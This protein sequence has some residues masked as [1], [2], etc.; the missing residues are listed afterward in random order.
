MTVEDDRGHGFLPRTRKSRA[1][2]AILALTSPKPVLRVTLA[3]ML[4]SRREKEQAR[5]SLRQSVHELQDTLGPDWSHLFQTDRHYL[6]LKGND[7][8]VDAPSAN[9]TPD[10]S[11]EAMNRYSHPLLEDLH[12]LDPAFD[13]W[14]DE[15]RLRCQRIGRTIGE[16]LLAKA[17]DPRET[18]AAA[19]G[20]LAL[21]RAHEGAWRA[22]MHG[23]AVI[24]EHTAA[25]D[26]Y[27][28]C[29]NALIGAGTARPSR[30][31]EELAE[32]LRDQAGGGQWGGQR[33]NRTYETAPRVPSAVSPVQP[34]VGGKRDNGQ[35]RLLVSPLRVIGGDRD[36]FAMAL[37]E[38]IS[39]GLSRFRWLSC[40]PGGVEG[41]EVNVMD[42]DMVLEGTVQ[43]AGNR[44]RTIV[45]L[46]DRRIDGE[47]IWAGRF[48]RIMTDPLS[49][50]DELGASIVAQI[51]PE[52]MRHE[53]KRTSQADSSQG[54]ARDLL[55]R[56][57]PGIYRLDQDSFLHARQLLRASLA[58]D[59]DSS[60]TNGWLAYWN[61]LY[62]GQG[63]AE[64]SE[65]SSIE[66][67]RL[68][69]RAVMLDPGDARAL[70]LAGHVRGF[71]DKRPEE[72]IALHERAI[73]LN[74]NMALAWCFSGLAYFYIGQHEEALRRIRQAISLSPSDPHFFFFDMALILPSMMVGD[75]PGAIAA[76]RRAIEMN[77]Q[78]SS[79]YKG[80]LA[81]LGHAGRQRDAQDVL[82]R[83]MRLEPGFSVREAV[84]R[85]PMQRTE[86]ID[87]YAE[88][89]RRAGL[90]ESAGVNDAMPPGKQPASQ[91][92][93]Q[94]PAIIIE[95]SRIDLV[96][97]AQH[98]PQRHAG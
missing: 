2:L 14:L 79:S 94:S 52:L 25:L 59:P 12:G 10:V 32:R 28:D 51:D 60:E 53:G 5:A 24:G 90:Q 33:G 4:W 68:A 61:L 38:E 21:D 44:V 95:H 98:S 37:S 92:G 88:G 54:S 64:D 15:E 63:W 30:E 75:H 83:L 82:A 23:H 87:R 7:L 49:L 31:T 73:A 91:S 43:H 80:Y 46:V 74:P 72:A 45:K 56:A 8:V 41:A 65:A 55:L 17:E 27:N 11:I 86:D 42:A 40:V 62:V 22:M 47:I 96:A 76:G 36:G 29:C 58:A 19:R 34:P 50:Q 20:L 39:A 97:R 13:R 84:M 66:A 6:T 81:V 16:S 9:K 1:M 35:L 89:L 93:T 3:E 78:F 70:T 77:P 71:I 18:I 69:E 48:D 57:L 26:C 85:S 67:A